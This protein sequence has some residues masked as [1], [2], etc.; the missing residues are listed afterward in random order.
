MQ[1]TDQANSAAQ[2]A[3]DHFDMTLFDGLLPKCRVSFQTAIDYSLGFAPGPKRGGAGSKI[4]LHMGF[5]TAVPPGKAMQV[6]VHEMVH[7][8]QFHFG[9][10]GAEMDHNAEFAA[11]SISIGLM[12]SSTGGFG[13][14]RTGTKIIDYVI[15]GGKFERT[16]PRVSAM[17]EGV[18]SRPPV[19]ADSAEAVRRYA[20]GGRPGSP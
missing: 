3:Y 12:P 10:P 6:L 18:F 2:A 19:G 7:A 1:P 9:S 11:K 17:W 5:F 20:S 15:G 8:W 13:G 14:K 16:V 4:A